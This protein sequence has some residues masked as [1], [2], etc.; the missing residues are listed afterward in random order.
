MLAAFRSGLRLLRRLRRDAVNLRLQRRLP[1]YLRLRL[2]LRLWLYL[3]L[4]LLL[5]LRLGR[6]WWLQHTPR[7]SAGWPARSKLW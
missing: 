2:R 3:R 5:F 7:L 6:G 4:R 1:L